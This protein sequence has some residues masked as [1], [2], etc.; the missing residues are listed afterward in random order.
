MPE[1]L[2]DYDALRNEEFK[3]Y[4]CDM[5]HLVPKEK[6]CL[7]PLVY[8]KSVSVECYCYGLP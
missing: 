2:K 3:E 8:K 1:G 6:R 4:N 7:K 5:N